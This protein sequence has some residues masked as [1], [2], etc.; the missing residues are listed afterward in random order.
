L[1]YTA[2]IFEGR[3]IATN[4]FQEGNFRIAQTVISHERTDHLQYLQPNYQLLVLGFA[5]DLSGFG[6]TSMLPSNDIATNITTLQSSALGQTALPGTSPGVG[7]YF[8]PKVYFLNNF[9]LDAGGRLIKHIFWDL[10]GGMGPQ[11]F[12]T[13]GN[14][15]H[16]TTLVGTFNGSLICRVS[17]HITLQQGVYFLQAGR[18]YRRCV[19]Y[20]QCRYYF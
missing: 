6:N 15:L 16:R 9:R 5:H 10:G 12:D 18:S 14:P 4:F 8:S 1:S 13:I 3:K 7:G 20:Q 17:K 2:G 11:N 19:V